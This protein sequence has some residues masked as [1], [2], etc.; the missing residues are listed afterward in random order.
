MVL[1]VSIVMWA[2]TGRSAV[3]LAIAAGVVAFVAL[4]GTPLVGS[5][6]SRIPSLRGQDAA[7]KIALA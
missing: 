4:F 5:V 1:L 6:A 2:L 7:D 3:T